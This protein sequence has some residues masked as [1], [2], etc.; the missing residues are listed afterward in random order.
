MGWFYSFKLKVTS[1]LCGLWSGSSTLTRYCS[2]A[3]RYLLVMLTSALLPINAGLGIP[4]DSGRSPSSFHPRLSA[5]Q[6]RLLTRFV[7]LWLKLERPCEERGRGSVWSN[8]PTGGG[9]L[10]SSPSTGT[11]S[12]SHL[13]DHIRSQINTNHLCVAAF[14]L[15]YLAHFFTSLQFFKRKSIRWR[16]HTKNQQHFGG[17]GGFTRFEI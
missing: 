2:C 13:S 7:G 10:T 1:Q 12:L 4:P 8:T 16:W 17:R 11:F 14:L 5:F 9:L 3:H 6:T 15:L